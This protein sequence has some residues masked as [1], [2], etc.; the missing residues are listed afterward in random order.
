MAGET[1]FVF[2][3]RA[4]Y[5]RLSMLEFC[6][7]GWMARADVIDH[8]FDFLRKQEPWPLMYERAREGMHGLYHRRIKTKRFQLI[9]DRDAQVIG[10]HAVESAN[11]YALRLK[12]QSFRVEQ[13]KNALPEPERLPGTRPRR[14]PQRVGII[15]DEGENLLTPHVSHPR[16]FRSDAHQSP[17]LKEVTGKNTSGGR[18]R[19][20][21]FP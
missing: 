1:G 13:T 16:Q 15:V 20:G 10:Y 7:D 4:E 19:K 9:G 14:D 12:P 11:E 21:V 6:V 8:R 18:I 3:K 2:A 17:A 5:K